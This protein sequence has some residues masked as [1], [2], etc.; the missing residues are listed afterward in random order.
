[1]QYDGMDDFEILNALRARQNENGYA[2]GMPLG[3]KITAKEA[4]RRFFNGEKAY[5][6]REMIL[7]EPLFVEVTRDGRFTRKEMSTKGILA[8][9]QRIEIQLGLR[10][11]RVGTTSGRRNA[12]T[13]LRQGVESGNCGNVGAQIIKKVINHRDGHQVLTAVYEEAASNTD[14]C[15]LQM[16]RT[17]QRIE[18]LRSLLDTRV[19]ELAQLYHIKH[20]DTNDP[21]WQKFR[22][23]DEDYIWMDRY[24]KAVDA[25]LAENGVRKHHKDKT[26]PSAERI[27]GKAAFERYKKVKE[28]MTGWKKKV[29][30]RVLVMKRREVWEAKQDEL[31]RMPGPEKAARRKKMNVRCFDMVDVLVRW[32][33]APDRTHL[34]PNWGTKERTYRV[35]TDAEAHAIVS[36]DKTRRHP[37]CSATHVAGNGCCSCTKLKNKYPDEMPVVDLAN[38]GGYN[39]KD[40][41]D[42]WEQRAAARMEGAAAT[43]TATAAHVRRRTI[44]QLEE[45]LAYMEGRMKRRKIQID[46]ATAEQ[47]QDQVQVGVLSE[48]LSR[49]KNEAGP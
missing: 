28:K 3:A 38:C 39:M 29:D 42:R 22:D 13:G 10:P 6:D 37:R 26:R 4:A 31:K 12:V 34:L 30:Y 14:H 24:L 40:D 33:S 49:R 7:G 27:L 19:D 44:K 48:E 15:A 17:P 45:D 20:V 32:G 35:Y 5:L 16:Q 21:I 36:S 2:G 11:Q 43:A 23:N 9:F 8:A 25:V 41:I 1:M 47:V 18:T 46:T